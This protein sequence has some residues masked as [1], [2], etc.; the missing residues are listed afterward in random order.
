[1]DQRSS[2]QLD[3]VIA[4]ADSSHE[5]EAVVAVRKA[6]QLLLKGGLS[7]GDLAKAAINHRSHSPTFPSPSYTAMSG[8]QM[9]LEAQVLK[10]RARMDELQASLRIKNTQL[11]FWRGRA[12]GLETTLHHKR[13]EAESWKKLAQNTVDKLWELGQS[14][15]SDEFAKS[16]PVPANTHPRVPSSGT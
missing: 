2:D 3:K 16:E 4:M 13:T 5:G 12:L 6:R 15:R 14:L 10:M 11:E 8:Q 7:F 9:H 1:M